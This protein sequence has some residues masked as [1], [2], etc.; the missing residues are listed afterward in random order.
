MVAV[1]VLNN[2]MSCGQPWLRD[3]C[4]FTAWRACLCPRPS[5]HSRL[6]VCI[7]V[8]SVLQRVYVEQKMACHHWCGVALSAAQGQRA[9]FRASC[10]MTKHP[11]V[12]SKDNWES[13]LARACLSCCTHLSQSVLLCSNIVHAVTVPEW[14]VIPHCMC[15]CSSAGR[16]LSYKC[17]DTL[18]PAVASLHAGS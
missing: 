13:A 11:L 16:N 3:K 17:T 4:H 6:V 9:A 2:D 7:L 14:P 15:L 8:A 1:A 12:C 5:I 18:L 10:S